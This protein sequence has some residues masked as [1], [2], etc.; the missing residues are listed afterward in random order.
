MTALLI[1]SCKKDQVD[2]LTALTT[3]DEISRVLIIPDAEYTEVPSPAGKT[4]NRD[5]TSPLR[6]K[7]LKYPALMAKISG[8]V[9]GISMQLA[10]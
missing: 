2:R 10:T 5:I 1:D 7:L 3:P 6:A 8:I 4:V 9:F